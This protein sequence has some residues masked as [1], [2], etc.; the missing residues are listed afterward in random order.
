[1]AFLIF[2]VIEFQLLPIFNKLE[3][4]ILINFNHSAYV[5]LFYCVFTLYFCDA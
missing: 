1:M 3:I 5:V 4:I 2:T